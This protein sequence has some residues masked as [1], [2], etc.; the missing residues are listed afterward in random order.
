MVG[1]HDAVISSSTIR[2]REGQAPLANGIQAKGGSREITIRECRFEHAGGRAI[3]L[4]GS[5]GAAYFRPR[6]A[7]SEAANLRVERCTIIGSEAAF[8]FVGVDR[9]VVRECV[10][11]QPAK[12]CFRI[13]QEN[14]DP[15]LVACQNGSFERNIIAFRANQMRTPINI[16]DGTKPE[17]FRIDGNAWFCLDRPSQATPA[18]PIPET[19]PTHGLDPEFQ[20][21]E[22]GDLRLKPSSPFRDRASP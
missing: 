10:I 8:A 13:L 6:N 17:T 5:T 7:K 18:L 14:R 12:W 1:C 11:Y 2:H 21:P 9:A 16:G 20:N 19:N 22:A 4:G 3:N 15:S